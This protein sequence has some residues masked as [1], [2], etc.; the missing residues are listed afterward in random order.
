MDFRSDGELFLT[1]II[2]R[3]F[4]FLFL[5]MPAAEGLLASPNLALKSD[6]VVMPEIYEASLCL[7]HRKEMV[8]EISAANAVKQFRKI[9]KRTLPCHS[10]LLTQ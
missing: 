6:R 8:I 9:I 2:L 7:L 5:E 4:F 3:L 1:Q 10:R